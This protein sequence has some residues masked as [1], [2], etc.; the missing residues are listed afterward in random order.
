MIITETRPQTRSKKEALIV[1]ARVTR[2]EREF[3]NQYIDEYADGN[4]SRFVRRA[5]NNFIEQL[6]AGLM[7]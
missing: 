5:L 6:E 7:A 2:E 1:N 4:T 3:L